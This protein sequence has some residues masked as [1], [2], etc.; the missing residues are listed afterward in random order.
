M[1]I[2][3][4]KPWHGL[5]EF[6]KEYVIIVVGVLTAL[7]A[8]Q[9]VEWLH[10]RHEVHVARDAIA[11]D[12][13]RI[14]GQAAVKDAEGPCL[15]RKLS[16]LGDILD[17]AQVSK[18]L[19]PLG[20]GGVPNTPVWNLRSW[21]ALTTSQTLGHISNREQL[22]LT[23][24]SL[25]VDRLRETNTAE[26]QEWAVLATMVGPGRPTSD[27]EIAELRAA[28]G[29]AWR[30]AIFAKVGSRQVSTLVAGTGY[31]T[32]AQ[33]DASFTEGLE[34]AKSA[35]ACRPADP[36]PAHSGGDFNG[37]LINPVLRPGDDPYPATVGVAGA[38][39]TER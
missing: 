25:Y 2:H 1:D 10:W 17:N 7:G 15:S 3:K 30:D 36:P 32:H 38:L 9:A 20:Y 39:S 14:I 34:R 11:F 22:L 12:L 8:E 26:A 29:R 6:L 23:G 13:R 28:L 21:T 27:A 24:V 33:L 16:E 5:R 19:P 18:R 37:W 35:R 4:P 31:L